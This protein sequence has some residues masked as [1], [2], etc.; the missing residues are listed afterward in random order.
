V[1]ER[2]KAAIDVAAYLRKVRGSKGVLVCRKKKVIYSQGDHADEVFYILDG[3]VKITVVSRRGKEAVIGI[4]GRGDFV[5][6]GCLNGQKIRMS[7][8]TTIEPVS[9]IPVQKKQIVRLLRDEPDFAHHFLA[10]V[11]ARNSRFE[12][13]LVDQLSIRAK[14]SWRGPYC[15]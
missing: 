9:L 3:Q 12:E 1:S 14:G 6:E 2:T 11:L 13:D 4:L 8:V 5:G 10:Y 7:T 15:S